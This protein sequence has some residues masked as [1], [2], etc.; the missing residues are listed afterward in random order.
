[1]WCVVQHKYDPMDG[2]LGNVMST[3][4]HAWNEGIKIGE[5]KIVNWA[6]IYKHVGSSVPHLML[7]PFQG[8]P[9]TLRIG[10]EDG[11]CGAG[12]TQRKTQI[13][14]DVHSCPHHIA[15]DLHS[16]SEIVVPIIHNT[17]VLGVIDIDSPR[18]ATF[19]DVD[20]KYLEKIAHSIAEMWAKLK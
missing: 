17:H 11:V 2:I 1:M 9:A 3:L 7:G 10:L 14:E 12:A 15:C 20:Q 13:I 6:G 5:L 8:R 18:I 19:D 16:K 4:F